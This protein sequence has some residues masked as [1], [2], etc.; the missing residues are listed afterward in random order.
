MIGG[1]VKTAQTR[2]RT[3][4]WRLRRRFGRPM[5]PGD[6]LRILFY[7]RV[8]DD[9]GDPLA[10]SCDVFEAE[11]ALLAERGYQVL[12]VVEALDRLYAGT[13]EP[14]TIALTFDDGYV[15]NAVNALPVLERYGFRGTVFVVTDLV[16]GK[17]M[18][19]KGH[20]SPA[21]LLGWKEIQE[22]DG[23]SALAFEA[24]TVTHPNLVESSDAESWAE[25]DL[26]RRALG[27]VLGRPS[28]AFCYPGGFLGP[29][30]HEYVRR[31]GFRYAITTEPGLNTDETDP[32]LVRR[33]QMN[34][35]DRVIDFAAKLDGSHDVP[36]LGRRLYRKLKYGASDPLEQVR[37]AAAAMPPAFPPDGAPL[38]PPVPADDRPEVDSSGRTGPAGATSLA[39][40]SAWLFVTQGVANIGFFVAVLL[41]ARGLVPADRGTTAFLTLTMFV[42]GRAAMLGIPEAS[43]V[44]VAKDRGR[45][46]TLVTNLVLSSALVGAGL[47]G[48]VALIFVALGSRPA[49]I[50]D[51][52]LVVIA[53]V[54]PIATVVYALVAFFVGAGHTFV[55]GIL[56]MLHP[57][58]YTATLLV[59]VAFSTL[60]PHLAAIAWGA[61]MAGALLP[62]VVAAHRSYGFGLPRLADYLEAVR[63]GVLAWLGTTLKFL[64]FRIDQLL[65]GFITTE[66]VLGIYAVAVNGSEILLYLPSAT[67]LALLPV[68]A[69]ASAASQSDRTLRAFRIL[70]VITVPGTAIAMALGTVAIPL[71][72]GSRYDDSVSAFLLLAPG[73]IGYTAMTVFS[74]AALGIRL[75]LRSSVG[76]AA[77]FVF[78]LVCLVLL[79]PTY[80]ADGAALAATIAFTAGG[81]VQ[82]VAHWLYEPFPVKELLPGVRDVRDTVIAGRRVAGG[83]LRRGR[84]AE[85]HAGL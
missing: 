79:V 22:L 2:A 18:F 48:L 72:F 63:F 67:G 30:E 3:L 65:M 47:G 62:A 57:W 27:D 84:R 78:G 24:H 49:G 76:A 80:E 20:G 77:A 54:V 66:A 74:S 13:L 6:G 43:A 64:N 37:R 11:M 41:L 23:K 17:G 61:G 32:F 33:T 85:E 1:F 42:L 71:L 50:T 4:V 68:I 19:L 14:N 16:A 60:S 25:I 44:F 39:A 10:V 51:Q 34:R 12:D 45:A 52:D 40:G 73:A 59:V 82:V 5:T 75:P 7:H 8:A 26:S 35:G 46:P 69:R 15:D 9:P 56:N 81:I 28:L 58:I 36:L 70:M 53:I 21:P 83:Y 55:G 38:E 31:S 29:R